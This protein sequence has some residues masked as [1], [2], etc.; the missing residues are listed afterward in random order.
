MAWLKTL[1]ETYDV[2]SDL[3]GKEIN[4]Q[5]V[6]LPISHSTFNAQIEVTIDQDG[7]FRN[8]RKLEKGSDV[9]TIIP[10]TEDSAARSS[11]IAPHPLC[12]KLCYIAG[13]Y[14][15]YTGDDKEDY[16]EAYIEQLRKW[17]ESEH[18]HPMVQAIYRYLGKKTLIRDLMDSKALEPD[19]AGRLTDHV[20]IHGQGQT[21]ANVRFIVWGCGIPYE[22][23]KNQE[24]YR[25]YSEYYRQR[26]GDKKLCYASGE[27]ESCSDKHP[28]K[29]R[30]SADKAK[31]ISG[32]DESGFTYRGRF[33]SKEQ[34]VCVGYDTSQKAHNA[35][36]WLLQKQGYTRDESAIV[37]WIV[38]RDMRLPDIMKDSVN[39]YN[40]VDL[41]FDFD[42]LD[43]PVDAG[44][45]RHDTGKYFAEQ[46]NLAV[47]GYAGKIKTD[48]RVAI[49]SLDAATT[50]RLSVVYYDE[51]GGRQYMDAILNWQQH[52]KWRRNI[53]IG[54]AEEGRKRITCECTPS[55]RDMAL[56]AFGVQRTDRLEADSKLIR[57]TVKRLFPCITR[58]DAEIPPDLIRAA[59]QRASMPQTMDE[60]IWY[61][62]VLCVVCAMIRFHYERGSKIMEH[63]LEDNGKDR[64][65][66]FGRLLAVYDYMEQRALFEYDENGK[67]REMRT[68]NAKRYWNAYSSRPA[69]TSKT[70]RQNLL[71]Y[72]K[73]LNGYELMKF[74]E[75]MGEIMTCLAESGYDNTA[76]SEMYLPGYYQQMEYMKKAFQKKEQ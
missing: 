72:E 48:D 54:R 60:F 5:A 19:G 52:C 17:A 29:I 4:G 75:W 58:Q 9:V 51:M 38:N 66:L 61:N 24:L 62:D 42:N 49:I 33:T 34:A 14:T 10:V 69:R 64:S 8:A 15:S 27:I 73:K 13:D 50:G 26:S 41:D 55:P 37:C 46:F 12:D 39:A 63:F 68:T 7:N 40:D 44:G 1:A 2:Y 31:L 25:R 11:G 67:V 57:A 6:L 53:R 20:K 32:N 18:T 16:Y 28:S 65:V 35:L 36:R 3:A 59:A 21:G 22:V 47:N 70:I 23:W 56:A 45:N 43:E 30:N 71:A 74:E 76:L